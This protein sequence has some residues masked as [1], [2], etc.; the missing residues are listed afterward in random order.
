MGNIVHASASDYYKLDN[1]HVA[2]NNKYSRLAFI[3]YYIVPLIIIPIC[4]PLIA[5]AQSVESD[6]IKTK[7]LNEL[8]VQGRTQRVIKFGVEYIPDK[9]TK[10]TSLDATNLLLQMQIPQLNVTPGT[11]SVKTA[12]G[13]D[14]AMYID[15]APATEQDLQ[16]LRPED[17][18]RVEVLNYPDDPRFESA[19]HVVNF[20]MVHYEW[21]G[22]TKMSFFGKTLSENMINGDLYSKFVYKKWTIDANAS[23]SWTHL[24]RFSS[25]QEQTFRDVSYDGVHYD[26]LVRRSVNGMDYLNRA[27]NQWASIRATFN[28]QTSYIQHTVSFS[29]DGIP[30]NRNGSRVSFSEDILPD[31]VASNS[32]S[33]QS[34]FPK[35]RGYYQ[36]MLPKENTIVA[37][38]NFSYGSNKRNSFYQLSQLTPIINDNREKVYAPVA[39]LSYSKKFAHNNTF[40]TALMTYN[41][42]YKTQYSGS[43][44]GT[45]KL[46]SSENM[47]FLEYMQ[48]W[49]FGLSLYS[50]V[51]ASYVIGRVNGTNV[52]EQWNPRLGLQLEYTINDKHSASIEGWWGNSH[53]SPATANEALVQN[54]ELLWL[55]GNPDLRNT[56]FTSASASYTYIPT[57]KLSLSATLS[58]EGNPNKLAYEFYTLRGIDGL[59]RRSINSGDAHS[60]S[61]WLSANLRLFNNSLTFRVNG[62]AQRVV[63]TGCDSQ[64]MN[65]LFGSV[66]VQYA[67]GNWSGMLYYQTPQKDLN[68]WSNGARASFKSTYGLNLNYAIGDFKAGLQFRNWFQR[69]SY[70][71]SIFRSPRF[72]DWEESWDAGLSRNLNLTLSYTIPYG[73]KVS[74]NGELQRSGGVGSAI[75]Q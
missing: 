44:E 60:Y 26:E 38:W 16:G 6:T 22:Y 57:N 52:L 10:K 7:E 5:S 64:S 37:S 68:A 21:G 31:A 71:T 39:N 65:A 28:N 58:Y 47:L 59:V 34:I 74:R 19:P 8:V 50:R 30:V 73:K 23:A 32:Y 54:N 43:Y 40:R 48:N 12:S 51:G 2:R 1:P 41:T 3:R 14:V 42:I 29:R 45:Q 27:N 49:Q 17:V 63:L 4:W 11:T 36:F 67:R 18:L 35:I 69:D 61:A 53:P 24:D 46:L 66:Y 72:D 55:Q 15:Y 20:I 75:L 70:Y 13:K 25:T 33:Y 9:K 56:L 62:Q